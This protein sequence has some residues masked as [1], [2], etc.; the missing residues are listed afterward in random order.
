MSPWTDASRTTTGAWGETVR[1]LAS[2]AY[3]Q[4]Q[5]T[6][7]IAN[8]KGSIEA[9]NRMVAYYQLIDTFEDGS[10]RLESTVDGL[11]RNDAL[12]K[13]ALGRWTIQ[14]IVIHLAD[15]DA[16]ALSQMKQIIAE[17]NPHLKR[18]NQDA[19][20]D[21]LRPNAQD[22]NDAVALCVLGR[23]QFARVLR[24]LK[25]AD[26][27]RTGAYVGETGLVTLAEFLKK[28]ASHLETHL[29]RISTIRKKMSDKIRN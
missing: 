13:P 12:A 5:Y 18:A 9:A 7:E 10:R 23:R 21:R 29:M 27:V 2:K 14:E 25:E 15:M 6:A 22:L 4:G 16:I 1:A 20:T 3:H 11:T 19:F 8:S 17:D 28:T 26:F 24:E